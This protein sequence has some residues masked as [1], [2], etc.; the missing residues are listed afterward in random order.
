M[1]KIRL[2]SDPKS[3]PHRH[4]IDPVWAHFGD[5]SGSGGVLGAQAKEGRRT[6]GAHLVVCGPRVSAAH[7]AI[8]ACVALCC[9][10]WNGARPWRLADMR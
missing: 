5:F 9:V 10:E 7:H 4:K 1:L 3:K 6:L 8:L 2:Q